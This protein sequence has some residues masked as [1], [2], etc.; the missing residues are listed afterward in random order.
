MMDGKQGQGRLW[1]WVKRHRVALC[2]CVVIA[3]GLGCLIVPW[4]REE[5][6]I[7]TDPGYIPPDIEAV[8]VKYIPIQEEERLLPELLDAFF[9]T[10]EPNDQSQEFL[11][12]VNAFW[13]NMNRVYGTRPLHAD[14][15]EAIP[16]S[17]YYYIPPTVSLHADVLDP[18]SNLYVQFSYHYF[19]DGEIWKIAS[20]VRKQKIFSLSTG[21]DRYFKN[22]GLD[23]DFPG[24][25]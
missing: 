11:D 4:A 9:Q 24:N 8:L 12:L 15:P 5:Y 6:L 19:E 2:V 23:Y 14:N 7:A 25:P 21:G 10:A 3:V 18:A 1:A 22:E 13:E 20:I 16:G 17:R